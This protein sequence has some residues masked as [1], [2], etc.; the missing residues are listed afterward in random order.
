MVWIHDLRS[1][2]LPSSDLNGW[3]RGDVPVKHDGLAAGSG[4]ESSIECGEEKQRREVHVRRLVD[5]VLPISASSSN[6]LR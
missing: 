5:I 2:N 1:Y 4:I 6:S 3:E